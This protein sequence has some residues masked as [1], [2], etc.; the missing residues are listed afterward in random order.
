MTGRAKWDAWSG[1]SK[2]YA[3]RGVEAEKRYLDIAQNLGWTEGGS[4]LLPGPDSTSHSRSDGA[5]CLSGNIW[6][7][8]SSSGSNSGKGVGSGMGTSV[9]AM[10]PPLPDEKDAGTIHG[11]ALSNNTSGLSSFLQAHQN[12][13]IN[14]FDEHVRIPWFYFYLLKVSNRTHYRVIR[15][16]I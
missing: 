4:T 7:E 5:E 10:A 13:D 6:D 3:D 2:T 11:L 14:E 1:A 9:S 8:E 12:A 15:L 16:C